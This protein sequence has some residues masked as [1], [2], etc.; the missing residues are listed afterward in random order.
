ML[1]QAM[2][3]YMGTVSTDSAHLCCSWAQL[4]SV[5]GHSLQGQPGMHHPLWQH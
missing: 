3:T 1:L 2:L 5:L 4:Q